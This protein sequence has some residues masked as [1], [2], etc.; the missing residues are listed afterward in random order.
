MK[1][2]AKIAMVLVGAVLPHMC[3]VVALA[4]YTTKHPGPLPRPILVLLFCL[5]ILTIVGGGVLLSRVVRKRVKIETADEGKLRRARATK[6]MKVGLVVWGLILLN[7]VRLVAQHEVRWIYAIP[8]L[9]VD[10]LLIVAFW[11]SLKRLEKSETKGSETGQQH[12]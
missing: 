5:F 10:I 2:Q 8:G 12:T 7:G 4:F 3:A 6:G 9:G 11:I 1:L